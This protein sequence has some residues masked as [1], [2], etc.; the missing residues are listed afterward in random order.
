MKKVLF[1]SHAWTQDSMNRNTHQRVV[2]LHSEL[3]MLGWSIWLDMN[4]L[5]PGENIDAVIAKGISNCSVIG[6]CLT[7]S[8]IE[9][10]EKS[11][12]QANGRRDNCAK[13]WNCCTSLG[14]KMIPFIMEPDMR[15]IENWPP[16][17]ITMYLG[18]SFYVDCTDDNIKLIATRISTMLKMMGF[19]PRNIKHLYHPRFKRIPSFSI[20]YKYSNSP[21]SSNNSSPMSSPLKNN[22]ARFPKP[23]HQIKSMINI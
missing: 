16:G 3:E 8:Y 14:K 23:V 17:I 9:K 11:S 12:L 7:K 19:S 5:K 21:S 20:L 1:L 13:E 4:E 6:I 22:Q 10:V 15:N 2:A 18:N